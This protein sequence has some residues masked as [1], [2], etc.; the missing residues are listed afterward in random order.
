MQL[1]IP[2][3]LAGGKCRRRVTLA[4]ELIVQPRR[5]DAQDL[6]RIIRTGLMHSLSAP[7]L[8]QG[9][10][11]LRAASQASAR[12]LKGAVLQTLHPSPSEWPLT[13]DFSIPYRVKPQSVGPASVQAGPPRSAR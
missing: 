2:A 3:D 11:A 6:N 12:P 10:A 4:L 9:E 5:E 8:G 13:C 1:S 7:C